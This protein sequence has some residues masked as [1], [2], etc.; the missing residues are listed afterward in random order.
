MVQKGSRMVASQTTEQIL[1]KKSARFEK[2]L[3]TLGS[4]PGENGVERGESSSDSRTVT[5]VRT[6]AATPR[7]GQLD[8][9]EP[10]Y[11]H[12]WPLRKPNI[13]KLCQ[14]ICRRGKPFH[15]KMEGV[16]QIWKVRAK[17]LC[18]APKILFS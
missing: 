15:P 2:R 9:L 7:G 14:G 18:Q 5:S 13:K 3:R 4:S 12:R 1:Q 6:R 17:I 11:S 10:R 8:D 16:T